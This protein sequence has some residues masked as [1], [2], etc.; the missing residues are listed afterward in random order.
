L[1]RDDDRRNVLSPPFDL[2]VSS[3]TIYD[4][5]LVTPLFKTIHALSALSYPS[6]PSPPSSLSSSITSYPS[7]S[8][9]RNSSKAQ[10]CKPPLIYLAVERRDPTLITTAFTRAR[11]EWGLFFQRVPNKKLKRAGVGVG[12]DDK[13]WEGVEVW[14]GRW[15]GVTGALK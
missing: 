4:A 5:A 8:T 11:E 3:D 15:D 1:T 7:P 9:S 14:H 12:W 10:T 13:E 6:T 2:I